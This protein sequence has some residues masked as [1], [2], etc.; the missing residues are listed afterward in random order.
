MIKTITEKIGQINKKA[1]EEAYETIEHLILTMQMEPGEVIT[2]MALSERLNISRT[3]IREAIKKLEEKGLIVTKNGRKKVYIL[4]IKE[5]EEIFDIKIYLEGA[6]AKW[7]ALR[8]EEAEFKELRKIMAEMK[9]FTAEKPQN[10]ESEA[11]RLKNWLAIDRKL[12]GVVFKMAK[13]QKSENIIK[14][15]NIQWHRLKVG[16]LALEGRIEKTVA[17]HEAFVQAI[18]EKNPEKAE[19]AMQEHMKNVKRELIK[20]MK[21]FHYPSA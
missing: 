8:G 2:E 16:M 7:A 10:E 18:L 13:N 20:L 9:A 3:P 19:Q 14:N 17:E 6:V 11:L 4:T 1:W 15:M 21:V 5:I 12:H